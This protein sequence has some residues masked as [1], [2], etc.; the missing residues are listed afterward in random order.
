MLHL[1]TPHEPAREEIVVLRENEHERLRE[2]SDVLASAFVDVPTSTAV[3]GTTSRAARLRWLRRLF[4]LRVATCSRFGEPSAILR[5]GR[6]VAVSLAYGPGALPLPRARRWHETALAWSGGVRAG[7]RMRVLDR[8]QHAHHPV[9]PHWYLYFTGVAPAWRGQ[10][11]GLT[12]LAR[13]SRRA[14]HDGVFSYLET[15]RH[16]LAELYAQRLGYVVTHTGDVAG[17]G[18][19]LRNWMMMRDGRI[20]ER[21]RR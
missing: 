11:L 7:H 1:A 9:A 14:D 10:G 3:Y 8:Y 5:S 4:R 15:D 13:T 21:S 6:V 2:A 16:G 12:L 20:D 17:L 19:T 18:G